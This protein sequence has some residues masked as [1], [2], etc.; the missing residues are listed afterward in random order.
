MMTIQKQR[1]EHLFQSLEQKRLDRS[2]TI[3][4]PRFMDIGKY[5]T[6]NYFYETAAR[7]SSDER[8]RSFY[9]SLRIGDK[10]IAKVMHIYNRNAEVLLV[11]SYKRDIHDLRLKA[12][13]RLEPHLRTSKSNR[14]FNNDNDDQNIE[15]SELINVELID[16]EH[17][18]YHLDVIRCGPNEKYGHSEDL[19]EID[20]TAI[21]HGRYRTIGPDQQSFYDYMMDHNDLRNPSLVKLHPF[22]SMKNFDH[23][24][25]CLEY[26]NEIKAQKLRINYESTIIAHTSKAKI[27][28]SDIEQTPKTV[29]DIVKLN[30][31]ESSS[32]KR[33][34]SSS[35]TSTSSD[36][37]S[38]SS[39]SSH[40]H[41]RHRRYKSKD[42]NVSNHK[43]TKNKKRH[44]H[45]T[46]KSRHNRISDSSSE[47]ESRKSHKRKKRKKKKTSKYSKHRS[48]TNNNDNRIDDKILQLLKFT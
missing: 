37:E 4:L 33:S 14:N 16:F 25:N 44:H 38:S 3:R 20:E 27:T 35:T 34:R 10:F 28:P 24:I 21:R 9:K 43:Q 26:R 46:K 22:T 6:C 1:S 30:F 13:L 23:V 7:F 8:R 29:S 39:L 41:H 12:N 2:F 47:T 5:I 15:R 45:K 48:R 19:D 42:G 11:W 31:P 17:I 18:S 40:G 36:S 32:Q